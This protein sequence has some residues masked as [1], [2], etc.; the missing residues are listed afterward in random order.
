MNIINMIL[1]IIIQKAFAVDDTLDTS[2]FGMNIEID[3]IVQ[4]IVN[5]LLV[6]IVPVATALF[7]VGAFLYII[8][9]EKE[10]RKNRGKDFMI[11]ALIGTAV[12][13]GAKGIVNLT[14]YFIYGS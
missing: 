6:T 13:V 4:N 8:S 1:S 10:D 14:M 3:Q 11:G 7:A 9:G 12:V 2:K 5:V